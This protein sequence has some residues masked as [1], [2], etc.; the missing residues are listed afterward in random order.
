MEEQGWGSLGESFPLGKAVGQAILWGFCLKGSHPPAVI[1]CHWVS[2][3]GQHNIVL[4][5]Q[6]WL[7]GART[8]REMVPFGVVAL[9]PRVGFEYYDVFND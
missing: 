5:S 7:E 3:S 6:L 1:G 8:G 4:A 9:R 2:D